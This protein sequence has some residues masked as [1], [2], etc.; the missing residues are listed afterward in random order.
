MSGSFALKKERVNFRFRTEDVEKLR[1]LA[2]RE[3]RSGS[4]VVRDLIDDAHRRAERQEGR[5][6]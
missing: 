1:I 4:E 5:R 3:G 2:T 6:K